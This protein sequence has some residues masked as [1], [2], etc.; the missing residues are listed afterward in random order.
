MCGNSESRT[1]SAFEVDRGGSI[2]AKPKQNRE[3]ERDKIHNSIPFVV[4]FLSLPLHASSHPKAALL[5]AL[6]CLARVN[7]GFS[8]RRWRVQAVWRALCAAP[9]CEN[10]EK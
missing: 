7:A 9:L 10:K 3:V 1:Q 6:V 4:P 8:A 5:H 2:T